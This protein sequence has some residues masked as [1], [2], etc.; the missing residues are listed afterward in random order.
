LY[1]IYGIGDVVPE[2]MKLL[3]YMTAVDQ[4]VLDKKSPSYNSQS[5]I[6]ASEFSSLKKELRSKRSKKIARNASYGSW[7]IMFFLLSGRF[8]VQGDFVD[9][10]SALY[11]LIDKPYSKSQKVRVTFQTPMARWSQNR[12][13]DTHPVSLFSG[14]DRRKWLPSPGFTDIWDNF[15]IYRVDPIKGNPVGPYW[16]TI[17]DGDEVATR[18]FYGYRLASGGYWKDV[19]FELSDIAYHIDDNY[20]LGV[21]RPIEHD[22]N[23]EKFGN[24]KRKLIEVPLVSFEKAK[25]NKRRKIQ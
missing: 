6:K 23:P 15:S 2:I 20:V 21:R 8:R 13:V 7:K 17:Y 22:L 18:P 10:N 19:P 9:T 14:P 25:S 4:P 5:S 1:Q 11:V 12:G 24:K 3:R 16:F